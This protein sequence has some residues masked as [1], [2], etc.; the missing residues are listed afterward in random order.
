MLFDSTQRNS[1]REIIK[2]ELWKLAERCED[3][4]KDTWTYINRL[5]EY[6]Q[7]KVLDA[8]KKEKIG[9]YH[10][11][12]STGYGYGDLGRDGLERVFARV[13]GTDAALVRSQI[14][15]GTHAIALGLFGSLRPGD[16]MLSLTGR[17]YDTLEEV[18][19]IRGAKY[20]GSLKDY[21]IGYREIEL[22]N[23]GRIDLKKLSVDMLKDVKLVYIQ[24]SRGYSW[25]RALTIEE[26]EE[27]I[28]TI[29]KI[30]SEII[31]FIDNCYGEFV[32]Q[33]EPGDV[34]ADLIAGSL[35]KNPGGGIA[36]GGGYLA[37]REDLVIKAA[38]RL[39]APGLGKAVGSNPAGYRLYYQ[40]L[41]L[42][43]HIVAQAL[44]GSIFTAK[45]CSELGFNVSPLFDE[46]RGD[47]IQ[48]IKFHSSEQL[49]KFCQ[50]IQ[51][52]SPVDS[53]VI[54]QPSAMPGYEDQ[55]IMAAGTFIQGS[56]LE[57]SADAPIRAPYIA[58]LQGGLTYNHVKLGVLFALQQ[59]GL[60]INKK[61][62]IE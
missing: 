8:F 40:G 59:L 16:I 31:C 62:N 26:I 3:E 23:E 11:T 19:G 29:K 35:I 20:S 50:S 44:K 18:I 33:L 32:E 27:V 55:V 5:E 58:Y 25:R 30:N 60:N 22:T 28:T 45:I 17:P 15:S 4:L 1:V 34:G 38:N 9:D 47:I 56:T 52:M 53:F 2:E 49:I 46:T 41:F 12:P 61:Q 36:P 6:N 7:L 43:P 13:M 24:R 51:T 57:F 48:T 21:G 39:T 54:P 37:G 42:A 10:F 14:V